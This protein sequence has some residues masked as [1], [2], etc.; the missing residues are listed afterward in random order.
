MMVFVKYVKRVDRLFLGYFAV[1]VSSV[2]IDFGVFTLYYSTFKHVL[3]SQIV[4]TIVALSYNYFLNYK[5]VFNQSSRS[6]KT[7]LPKYFLVSGLNYFLST[8]ML[9]LL[10]KYVHAIL[11]K[12]LV[13]CFMVLWNFIVYK[14]FIFK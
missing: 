11:A 5:F 6:V 13:L 4:S 8:I 2:I 9:L 10:A 14:R 3:Y 7:T 1:G 12:G